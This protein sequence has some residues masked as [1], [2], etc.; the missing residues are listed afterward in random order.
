MYGRG[1][2]DDGGIDGGGVPLVHLGFRLDLDRE[3]PQ[4]AIV[5]FVEHVQLAAD[6][7]ERLDREQQVSIRTTD[8]HADL[9]EAILLADRIVEGV[10]NGRA[11][12]P[13]RTIAILEAT[14]LRDRVGAQFHPRRLGALVLPEQVVQRLAQQDG[15]LLLHPLREAAQASELR[16]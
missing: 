1:G 4:L 13:G 9:A 14:D 2:H 5:L 10:V 15:L 3:Q 6:R 11:D 12:A 16:R 8:D 7:I